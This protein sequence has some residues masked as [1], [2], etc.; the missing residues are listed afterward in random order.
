MKANTA[1]ALVACGASLAW[2][3]RGGGRLRVVAQLLAGAATLIGGLT[4]TEL[5]LV[6]QSLC[7]SLIALYHARIK[8]PEPK[9]GAAS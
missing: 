4:L 7:K 3:V 5:H 2:T 8:Y 1:V 9:P 6:E